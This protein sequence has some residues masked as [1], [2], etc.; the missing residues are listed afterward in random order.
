MIM[1]RK[2]ESGESL[3]LT[4][5]EVAKLLGISSRTVWRMLSSGTL[6]VKPVAVGTVAR[7]RRA[8]IEAFADGLPDV[9]G[10]L[11]PK[12][13]KERA[14]KKPAAAKRGKSAGKR[15]AKPV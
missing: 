8:D 9:K 3:L 1:E 5:R 10:L 13:D 14:A 2:S 4:V 6:P 11:R 15:N 7:W 12:P